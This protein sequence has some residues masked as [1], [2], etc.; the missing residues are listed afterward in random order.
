MSALE[1]LLCSLG[2]DPRHAR[3]IVSSQVYEARAAKREAIP[4]Y[5]HE[6]I[7]EILAKQG[8]SD[9]YL[10]QVEALN[11][12]FAGQ[13]IVIST[14]VSSGKSLAYWLPILQE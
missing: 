9:L 7:K 12:V 6:H 1:D 4:E 3:T 13:N 10:H 11:K 8:I 2:Q 14:G 5:I